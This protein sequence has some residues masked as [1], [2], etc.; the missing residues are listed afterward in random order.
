[1]VWLPYLLGLLK[2]EHPGASDATEQKEFFSF[3]KKIK[4]ELNFLFL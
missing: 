3:K 2:E 4:M 1:M